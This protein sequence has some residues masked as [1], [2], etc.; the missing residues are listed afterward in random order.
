MPVWLERG[1]AAIGFRTAK[2]QPGV[3][4]SGAVWLRAVTW[5]VVLVS[6]FSPSAQGDRITYWVSPNGDDGWPGTAVAPF[7][8]LKGARDAMR[9]FRAAYST[10]SEFVIIVRDGTYRLGGTL[11]L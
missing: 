8:T 11:G 5:I 3:R 2:K 7:R 6:V 10:D 9:S 4:R 1:I